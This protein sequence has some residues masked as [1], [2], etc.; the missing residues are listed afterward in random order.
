MMKVTY[1]MHNALHSGSP[2]SRPRLLGLEGASVD[3]MPE[4]T[5][6][7]PN[8]VL[9]PMWNFR[10]IPVECLVAVGDDTRSPTWLYS[11]RQSDRHPDG[12]ERDRM[13]PGSPAGVSDLLAMVLL[14][15]R[16]SRDSASQ[17]THSLMTC[18]GV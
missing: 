8:F 10:K 4:S 9:K 3:K 17:E 7:F 15:C 18:S 6:L 12:D 1:L 16:S 11:P 13:N 5:H 2:A 14:L